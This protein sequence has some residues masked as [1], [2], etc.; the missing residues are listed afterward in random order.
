[1]E[2]QVISFDEQTTISVCN[3]IDKDYTPEILADVLQE[4][5]YYHEN[6]FNYLRT[7]IINYTN[8]NPN[9]IPG[10]ILSYSGRI[11]SNLNI[12]RNF[13]DIFNYFP[14]IPGDGIK[15][16]K[17]RIPFCLPVSNFFSIR[18]VFNSNCFHSYYLY[19]FDKIVY[20]KESKSIYTII[21]IINHY[22]LPIGFKEKHFTSY[23]CYINYYLY[24]LVVLKYSY[25]P[26]E[27]S[28]K[29]KL[30]NKLKSFVRNKLV[31]DYKKTSEI[32]AIRPI[33]IMR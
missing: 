28:F 30:V 19:E 33:R 15:S 24:C 14:S 5:G 3:I 32:Y 11:T 22:V 27:T 8:A 17:Y 13:F 21:D 1:M 16:T 23:N 12:G 7:G 25:K 26:K 9:Y 2:N 10:N 31:V 6:L 18:V 20:F 29:Q 4:N